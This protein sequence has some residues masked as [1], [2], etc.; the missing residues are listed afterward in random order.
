[1]TYNG[2][3]VLYSAGIGAAIITGDPSSG[4]LNIFDGLGTIVTEPHEP[5]LNGTGVLHVDES[6][7]TADQK[8]SIDSMAKEPTALEFATMRQ[9]AMFPDDSIN[10]SIEV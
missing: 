9:Y 2:R 3:I 6:R 1:M 5:L 4:S 8:T 10:Y 7:L